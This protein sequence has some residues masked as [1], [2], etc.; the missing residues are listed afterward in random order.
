MAIFLSTS[1]DC[2][3]IQ[4]NTFKDNKQFSGRKRKKS[5]HIFWPADDYMTLTKLKCIPRSTIKKGFLS[6]CNKQTNKQTK[7]KTFNDKKIV[8]VILTPS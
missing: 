7:R 6:E 8:G 1:L 2:G 3:P 5:V 4:T